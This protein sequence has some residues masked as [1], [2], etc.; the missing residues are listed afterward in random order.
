MLK[1]VV[2][3]VEVFRLLPGQA[4]GGD[5]LGC[6]KRILHHGD[7]VSS[8]RDSGPCRRRPGCFQ[9]IPAPGHALEE[10]VAFAQTAHADVLVFEHG[11]DDAQDWLRAEVI[12]AVEF[13]HILEDLVLVQAG[14]FESALLE[15]VFM[16]DVAL[17]LLAEPAVQPR[18]FVEFRAG[19][20]RSQRDLNGEDFQFL[21]EPDGLFDGFGLG[22]A[23]VSPAPVGVPPNGIP[24]FNQISSASRRLQQPGRSR[25]P[26][27]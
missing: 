16:D 9:V 22:S 17:V 12:A 25:S 3:G 10:F 20:G 18:L 19:I 11:L 5:C 21:R 4:I 6:H 13:L 7:D 27:S 1:A 2:Y 15:A 23:G 26:V 14:I 8:R 24:E